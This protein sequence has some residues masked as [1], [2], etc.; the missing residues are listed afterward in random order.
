VSQKPTNEYLRAE[1]EQFFAWCPFNLTRLEETLSPEDKA[2]LEG[3]KVPEAL[4]SAVQT[5]W[6]KKLE[7]TVTWHDHF[8]AVKA[9]SPPRRTM[10]RS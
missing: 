9:R 1:A 10:T 7:T 4:H 6:L 5:T 3:G 2:E 8:D